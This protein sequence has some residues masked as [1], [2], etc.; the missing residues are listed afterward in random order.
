MK[1]SQSIKVSKCIDA[2]RLGTDPA[3]P[4]EDGK[5][6]A[7]VFRFVGVIADRPLTMR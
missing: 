3:I 6:R 1:L 7:P 5:R 4:F 2:I